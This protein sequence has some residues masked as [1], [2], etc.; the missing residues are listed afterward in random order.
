[1]APPEDKRQ[2]RC[3]VCGRSYLHYRGLMR[4]RKSEHEPAL[5][6]YCL[7]CDH[8]SRRREN[9]KKHYK[10]EHPGDIQEVSSI[11][12]EPARGR[13]TDKA[14]SAQSLNMDVRRVSFKPESPP[15]PASS[16]KDDVPGT[17]TSESKEAVPKPLAAAAP[18]P[19]M[20]ELPPC[21]SPLAATPPR[22][23]VA[24][25]KEDDVI[26]ISSMP[27]LEVDPDLGSEQPVTSATT[28]SLAAPVGPDVSEL[29]TPVEATSPVLKRKLTAHTSPTPPDVRPRAPQRQADPAIHNAPVSPRRATSSSR[30][31][32]ATGTARPHI[33]MTD[34]RVPKTAVFVEDIRTR[35]Y[36]D[37]ICISDETRSR[38]YLRDVFVNCSN[39]LPGS[40]NH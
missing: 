3:T 4:H 37:N 11:R 38:T 39:A 10:I 30:P 19:E 32:P 35:I 12:L 26:S 34:K 13:P 5:Y 22:D 1:M 31:P 20:P 18:L 6:V 25:G 17:G 36:V 27:P 8:R 28:E 33:E 29:P 7:Q 40:R 9:L 15:R 2:H 24:D 16:A 14:G 23:E 21:L